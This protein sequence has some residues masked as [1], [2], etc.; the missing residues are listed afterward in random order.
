MKKILLAGLIL[1]TYISSF[2]QEYYQ[3]EEM[4]LDADSWFFY[5]DYQEALPLFQRV[6]DA[7]STNYNVM[8]KI[9]FC[10]L[11]IPGQKTRAIPYLEK[12]AENY[13][14][15][16]RNNT[17]AERQAP[18]DAIFYLGNA[19]LINNQ[20]DEA[21]DA[22]TAFQ[23]KISQ[24]KRFINKD[25]YDKE[26]IQKQFD[27][28]RNAL[29]FQENPVNFIASNLGNPINTR[30]TEFNPVVSGDG[31]TLVFTTSLQ[32]Y[33]AI[34]YAKKEDGKWGFP[35]NLMAQ[36]GVD[37]NTS[38]LSLSHDGKELYL[39]RDDDFDGN[40]YVSFFRNGR[41]TKVKK[42][43]EN[44]NTKYWESHAS[45]SPDGDKLYF[46]SNRDGGLGDLDIYVSERLTDTT[47]GVA[48]NLG[49]T[50][51]TPWN[52]NTPFLTTDGTKL[53]FSS[54]GHENM[55]GYDIFYSQ[56]ING[57]WSKPVNI[58]YPIN[59]TDHDLFFSPHE[60]GK[61]AYSSEYSNYSYG[62]ADIYLYQLF[63]IPENNQ[64]K[65]EGILTMD[66]PENRNRK[67]F[68]IHI[69]DTVTMDTIATLHPDEDRLDY[70]FRTSR[71]K[72]HLV[73]EGESDQGNQYFISK[74][75]QIKEVFLESLDLKEPRELT[76][77]DTVPEIKVERNNYQVQSNKEKVK[78]K[79]S[80]Q[81]GNKLVAETFY[82]DKLI[83]REEFDIQKE[84]F[85]YEYMPLEGK[86]RINFSLIDKHNNIKKEQVTVSYLPTD[87][88]AELAIQD[89]SVDFYQGNKKV[90]IKLSVERNSQLFVETWVED[91]LINQEQFKVKKDEFIYEFEPK[92]ENSRLLFKLVDQHQNIKNEEIII[93]HKPVEKEFADVLNNIIAF[94][95]E[96]TEQL[97]TS[98]E[99][100]LSKTPE[101]FISNFY[102]QAAKAGLTEQ[103]ARSYIIALAISVAP[104]TDAF[105]TDLAKMATGDLKFVLDSAIQHQLKFNSNLEVIS[106]L[107]QQTEN[108]SYSYHD[109]ILLL[110][111]YLK[112]S[113][114]E[115]EYLA[116]VLTGLMSHDLK[117]ILANMD[118]SALDIITLQDFRH[119]L[120]QQNRYSKEQ[121]EQIYSI[122]EGFLLSQEWETDLPTQDDEVETDKN[123]WVLFTSIIL[124]FVILG[125]IIIF[126]NRK[127]RNR[128]RRDTII[129]K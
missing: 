50:I 16:Y 124:C 90:K 59:T 95:S 21:I 77:E 6:L 9:G 14:L 37:D 85:I 119:Y 127:K 4:F 2:S 88:N 80:L 89:Q 51:N 26:Y 52:E 86:T 115:T 54:E 48:K 122:F 38:T 32:F 13:T 17:Y 101:E 67:D 121:L 106:Y 129:E 47:W 1:F 56:K 99:I 46:V 81:K 57:K 36:L 108:Y 97:M 30:F 84:D 62:G 70:Q 73:W 12:A 100:S 72:D 111:D 10:Y 34:F 120:S 112:N 94:D 83:N 19:Y 109:I 107:K 68:V 102:S 7:D 98:K 40:I 11:H 23:N 110:E 93:S 105:I 103:Q 31:S 22:Y 76:L 61:F 91:K 92:A 64:I 118:I 69:T 25:I 74:A 20:I 87:T 116:R 43:N 79:L 39:Y 45:L 27:A 65:V 42:L 15:N 66:N 44:I 3:L 63:H 123:R 96:A 113:D 114:F 24:N 125:L 71:G 35:V 53:F 41:W 5:E 28:C 8:Y 128:N 58:G 126:F 29:K 78:I 49:E 33:D 55:G 60:N 75:Y 117:Q 18:L 104:T 82:K